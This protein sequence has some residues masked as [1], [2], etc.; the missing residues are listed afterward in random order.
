MALEFFELVSSLDKN[1]D[2]HLARIL[3]LLKAFQREDEPALVGITKLAKLD[4]LLRYPACFETAMI[5]RKVSP[6]NLRVAEFEHATIEAS[7]VRYRYGPWD[8][9]Y[10][11]FLN[12][13]AAR[14]L[15]TLAV[16]GRTVVIDL[17][18]QGTMLAQKFSESHEFE[19][20]TFRA[21][22]LRKHLDL[23]AT[24]LMEFIYEEFPELNNMQLNEEIELGALA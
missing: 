1:E 6:K 8:H 18:N 23:G 19:D 16:D 10:R 15:I 7:M 3:V 20:V 12:L 13:L 5:A 17:T 14:G 4:F 24:R 22:M 2:I 11:K 21:G 9:R